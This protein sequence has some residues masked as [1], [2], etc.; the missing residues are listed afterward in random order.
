M[1][2]RA[3]HE[4]HDGRLKPAQ[5]LG[6]SV[7]TYPNMSV[8][9]QATRLAQGYYGPNCGYPVTGPDSLVR[10]F[11]RRGYTDTW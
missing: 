3:H 7:Q 11:L 2:L 10:F 9:G 8:D 6:Q 4:V 1:V 5:F